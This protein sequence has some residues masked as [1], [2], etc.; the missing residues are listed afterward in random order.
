MDYS[1]VDLIDDVSSM[2][3]LSSGI[4]TPSQASYVSIP[5]E[6]YTNA[7]NKLDDLINNGLS[8]LKPQSAAQNNIIDMVEYNQDVNSLSQN[9]LQEHRLS[10]STKTAERLLEIEDLKNNPNELIV[11]DMVE[12]MGGRDMINQSSNQI[13]EKIWEI[14]AF[15]KGYHI[16]S[17]AG[18]D[19]YA[20]VIAERSYKKIL[21]VAIYNLNQSE[22]NNP[23]NEG[24][25]SLTQLKDLASNPNPEK[26]ITLVENAGGLTQFLNEGSKHNFN[27][28]KDA[29]EKSG[30]SM[31]DLG[32][33]DNYLNPHA[34]PLKLSD[35]SD[36]YGMK[37]EMQTI[38]ELDYSSSFKQLDDIKNSTSQKNKKTSK[39]NI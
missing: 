35:L 17:E 14:E 37:K 10:P 5:T 3:H 30:I 23:T 2:A 38:D 1:S 21:D 15:K 33:F 32:N 36:A 39:Y 31:E 19:G 27:P 6:G 25:E 12:S 4:P 26:L 24:A 16:P 29:L 28:N 34:K 8:L 9:A 18:V 7:V 22:Y 13:K 20:P 11:S